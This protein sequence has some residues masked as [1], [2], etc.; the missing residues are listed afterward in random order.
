MREVVYKNMS[1]NNPRKHEVSMEE[2][3][4]NVKSKIIK[5][6]IC[7]YF[8]KARYNSPNLG[9]LKNWIE[10]QKKRGYHR[11]CHVLRQTDNRMG[12]NKIICKVLGDIFVIYRKT[13]Y[14]IVYVN[15]V[16]IQVDED[17]NKK[18]GIKCQ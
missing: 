4:N 6:R 7:K 12:M 16:R 2:I 13:A 9:N 3:N 18:R 15:E 11:H 8:I 10:M 17:P 5:K 1:G 14:R